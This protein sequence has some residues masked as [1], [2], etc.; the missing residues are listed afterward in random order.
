MEAIVLVPVVVSVVV[1]I[2]RL[3]LSLSLSLFLGFKSR[4]GKKKDHHHREKRR[5]FFGVGKVR[6][7]RL[8]RERRAACDLKTNVERTTRARGREMASS[9]PRRIIK[10]TQRLLQEP[11]P[12]I[13]AIPSED[14]VRHFHV[15]IE[16]PTDS[17]YEGGIFRLELFLPDGYPM[18]P[19]K[20]LFKTKIYHP[21]IDKLGRIC[22]DVLKEKWSPALQIRTI[23][24]SVQA[25][26]STPNPDDPLDERIAKHW[27]ENEDEALVKAREMTK[28]HAMGHK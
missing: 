16:G 2:A 15:S 21:N 25:L 22:L 17:P 23:L 18:D 11:V 4:R 6:F 28:M 9:L 12:G 13:T 3:S 1:R 27:R 24:L 14:N 20:V 10:E 5:T 7:V 26:L 8:T 19:P